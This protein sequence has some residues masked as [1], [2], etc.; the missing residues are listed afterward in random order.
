MENRGDAMQARMIPSRLT[1]A[2]CL[3]LLGGLALG[4]EVRCSQANAQR[5]SLQSLQNQVDGLQDQLDARGPA[6]RVVDG[7]GD[8]IGH[9]VSWNEGV[10]EVYLESLGALASINRQ[11]GLPTRNNDVLF[12]EPDCRGQ[13]YVTISD[14]DVL[15]SIN[16]HQR[17]FVSVDSATPEVVTLASVLRSTNNVCSSQTG[18]TS[19]LPAQEIEMP[20]TLPLALPIQ[21]ERVP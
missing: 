18:S 6:I 15:L 11:A 14:A 16:N 21:L 7:N 19:F 2:T 1:I 17:F 12:A 3:L 8:D 9:L 4:A 10:A 20:F 5:T 13:P